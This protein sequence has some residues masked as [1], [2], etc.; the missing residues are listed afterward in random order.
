M[1]ICVAVPS[2]TVVTDRGPMQHMPPC[3]YG[4]LR[5]ADFTSTVAGAL[6]TVAVDSCA[7]PSPGQCFPQGGEAVMV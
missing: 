1:L 3:G 4:E 6:P 2:A 5:A 7:R